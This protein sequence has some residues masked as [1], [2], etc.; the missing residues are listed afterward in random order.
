MYK[1]KKK[2]KRKQW[3]EKKSGSHTETSSQRH[4]KTFKSFVNI[5]NHTHVPIRLVEK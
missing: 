2:K 1:K 5:F 3:K 4:R